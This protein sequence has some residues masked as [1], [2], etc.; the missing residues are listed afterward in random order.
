M[1][2]RV[3][4]PK[5]I[6]LFPSTNFKT[7]S[8]V[9]SILTVMGLHMVFFIFT[10]LGTCCTCSIYRF[11]SFTNLWQFRVIISD[12]LFFSLIVV[13]L[14]SCDSLWLH[15]LQHTRLLCPSL[16]PGVYSNSCL[17]SQWCHPTTSSSVIPFSSRLQSFPVQGLL[18]QDKHV[19]IQRIFKSCFSLWV[20]W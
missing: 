10:F 8:L 7:L 17:L 15:G 20:Q 4:V 13:Q 16:S 12:M 11:I 19:K 1:V 9:S 5:Y 3:V 2:I 14:L 6:K 18:L